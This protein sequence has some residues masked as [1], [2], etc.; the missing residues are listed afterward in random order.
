VNVES[1]RALPPPDELR[2]LP[3]DMLI[4]ILTSAR[5]LVEIL[6]GK[7]NGKKTK[8]LLPTP[9]ISMDPHRRVDTSRFL[10]QRTRRVSWALTALRKR[11]EVPVATE[12][13][14]EWRLYGPVGVQ[15]LIDALI[16]EAHSNDERAFLLCELALELWRVKPT[17]QPGYL[18][19]ARVRDEIRKI[20]AGI[21]RTALENLNGSANNLRAY[22]EQVFEAVK[23]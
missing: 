12:S 15:A 23:K 7:L 2:A 16:R 19:S 17:T 10:L 6:R 4:N 1:A 8:D 18:P 14:L 20:L 13:S 11:L 3:L 22:I 5:P 21:Q 9:E